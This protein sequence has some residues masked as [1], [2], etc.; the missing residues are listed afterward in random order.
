M[1]PGGPPVPLFLLDWSA[2]ILQALGVGKGGLGGV[3]DL[4]PIRF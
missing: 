3:I 1:G 2:G 4:S